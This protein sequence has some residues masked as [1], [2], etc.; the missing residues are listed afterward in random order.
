MQ[1]FV[2][3]LKFFCEKN[4]RL[5]FSSWMNPATLQS[6]GKKEIYAIVI[7][8][9]II[10]FVSKTSRKYAG[11]VFSQHPPP[12]THICWHK[13]SNLEPLVLQTYVLPTEP[14]LAPSGRRWCGC[15]A[16]LTRANRVDL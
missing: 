9:T 10:Y 15:L 13:D 5:N 16:A 7:T 14:L 8:L 11:R 6:L 4:D 3:S 2:F 12:S 1:S